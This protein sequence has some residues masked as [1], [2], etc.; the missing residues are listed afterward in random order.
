M[1]IRNPN[2]IMN[3]KT[4]SVHV[5]CIKTAPQAKSTLP[6]VEKPH[7]KPGCFVTVV[8]LNLC[9][10]RT[11]TCSHR[12]RRSLV[13][14]EAGNLPVRLVERARRLRGVG[15]AAAGAAVLPAVHTRGAGPAPAH[16]NVQHNTLVAEVVADVAVGAGKV[17]E[18]GAPARRVGRGGVG[19]VGGNAGA[20]EEP[21][22]DAGAA[23]LEGVDAAAGGIQD[24][25]VGVGRGLDA[26]AGVVVG[27]VPAVCGEDGAGLLALVLHGAAF[28][29][30]Q[31]NLV[32]GGAVV[33]GL[34]DIDLA[35]GGPVGGVGQPEG[36]PCGATVGSVQNVKD[37]ESSGISLLGRD[38]GRVAAGSG[39]LLGVVD[40]EDGRR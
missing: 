11:D 30:V 14:A 34:D 39:I 7:V 25:P 1:D 37:E 12:S 17:G 10:T 15:G 24:G 18:R 19:D 22:T 40:L 32:S 8:M 2:G 28:C 31:G 23:E 33:D 16:V 5:W 38:A 35:V 21:D 27:A 13:G 9:S 4:P 3:G 6:C 26:A 29:C 20:G 36:G